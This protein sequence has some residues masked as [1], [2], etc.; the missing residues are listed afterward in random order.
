V[1]AVPLPLA[2]RVANLAAALSC[3][4]LD[5]RSAIPTAAELD[6]RSSRWR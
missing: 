1:G 5:G 6:E 2:L 3:R 4:A